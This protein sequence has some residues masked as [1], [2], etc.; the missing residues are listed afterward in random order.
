M[1]CWHHI[2]DNLNG[3]CPACRS[4]YSDDPH[5]F[6]AVDRKD[7][8]RSEKQK[9]QRRAKGVAAAAAAA[10]SGTTITA[11]SHA[12]AIALAAANGG[13]NGNSIAGANGQHQSG[14][15][16]IGVGSSSSGNTAA[17]NTSSLLNASNYPLPA[18]P[19]VNRRDLH[20]MRVIQVCAMTYSNDT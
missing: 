17:N 14:F 15:S 11:A 20:H 9:Q 5:A 3:L 6:S 12:A 10:A 13:L 1:W 18:R 2:K 8:I 16:G 7:V 19:A 4:P